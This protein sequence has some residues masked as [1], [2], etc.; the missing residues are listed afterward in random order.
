M[1]E[2]GGG[3]FIGLGLGIIGLS[4]CAAS[5]MAGDL[6]S[7]SSGT[8]RADEIN[9]E[10]KARLPDLVTYAYDRNPVIQAAREAWRA[11]AEKYRISVSLPDPQVMV[12][13]FPK[14]I[15]T[16]LGP[17]DWNASISQKF[18]FPGRLSKEGDVVAQE[19]LIARLDLD[20]A[21]RDVSVAIQES[22]HEL[23]YIQQAR[24]IAG[25]NAGLLDELRK[26][27][28]TAYAE[29]RTTFL[30]VAKSQSQTGQ[31]RYDML[32]LE[33]L[34]ETERTRLNGL[35]NRPPEAS[36]AELAPVAAQ[37]VVYTL[38]EIYALAE[39]R[40]EEIRIAD[41]QVEKA[42]RRIELARYKN[43]PDFSLGLFY[44]GIG[45][46]DVANPP[47][48]AGDDAVGI[49]FGVS[50]PLWF[51]KNA[52]RTRQAR[53]DAEKARAVRVDRVNQSLT[54]IRTLFFKLR[55]AQRLMTL[56]GGE[57]IPQALASMETAETWF[58]EGQGSFSDFV[59]IQAT[60]YNF[61]LSVARARADYGK[62]LAG[63]ERLAGLD[64][65]QRETNTAGEVKQ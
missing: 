5:L 13:Y 11:V 1:K 43:L 29:D 42:G 57:M 24:S 8:L 27:S 54:Q 53:A 33:E 40:Q 18:P 61:Q 20:K 52:S 59:E 4:C 41:A 15:E 64:L 17:Q 39:S 19:V 58:R 14:P 34:E 32:L 50:V 47:P 55:N 37:P 45:Q 65:T 22:Y 23:L 3:I 62:A 26:I 36:I 48:D 38:E 30:D 44:A 2:I 12:T 56:Y 46:P 28:E 10:E 49:Q 60:A 9:L 31:L 7:E 21:V 16:R 35:L 51:G 25:K 6:P 63:L